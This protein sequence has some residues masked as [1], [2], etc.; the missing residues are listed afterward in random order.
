MTDSDYNI[1]ITSSS[2]H[3]FR[4]KISEELI[5]VSRITA[6]P[7]ETGEIKFFIFSYFYLQTPLNLLI[8]N[9]VERK[10]LT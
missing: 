2:R 4:M 5:V 8:A 3:T 7:Q 9:K 6:Q 1:Y 10:L